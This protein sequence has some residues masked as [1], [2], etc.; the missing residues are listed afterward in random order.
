MPDNALSTLNIS[1]HSI[2]TKTPGGKYHDYPR[3]TDKETET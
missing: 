1:L 2:L 3:L